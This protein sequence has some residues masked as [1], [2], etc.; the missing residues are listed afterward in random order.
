VRLGIIW[1]G[2]ARFGGR[3]LERSGSVLYGLDGRGMAV[4]VRRGAVRY[5]VVGSGRV[6]HG[7]QVKA[8]RGR[9]CLV[10]QG[11][12]GRGGRG[13]V[14]QGTA[15]LARLGGHGRASSDRG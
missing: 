9:E 15:W 10:R 7:G 1:R 3:G 4:L 8:R 11:M 6:R 14:R 5:R 13:N 2:V 12:A